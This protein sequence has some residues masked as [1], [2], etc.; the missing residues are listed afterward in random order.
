MRQRLCAADATNAS[1]SCDL[2]PLALIAFC[3]FNFALCVWVFAVLV[4]Y[5]VLNIISKA[6]LVV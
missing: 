3:A 1:S 5:L 2:R 6:F 4:A